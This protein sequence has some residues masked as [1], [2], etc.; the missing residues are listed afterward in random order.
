[1]KALNLGSK[2]KENVGECREYEE[3]PIMRGR[4]LG[5]FIKKIDDG[6]GSAM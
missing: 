5:R 1:M 6:I 4:G 3:R 2:G